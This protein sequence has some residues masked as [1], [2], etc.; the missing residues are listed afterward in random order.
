MEDVL[1]EPE[2]SSQPSTVTIVSEIEV[3]IDLSEEQKLYACSAFTAALIQDCSETNDWTKS[4]LER[5]YDYFSLDE[6]LRRKLRKLRVPPDKI[7]D[8]LY[9]DEVSRQMLLYLLGFALGYR[10]GYDA[11]ARTALLVVTTSWN[12]PH[13]AL[14]KCENDLST[15][16]TTVQS[17]VT[18]GSSS[19]TS[20][21]SSSSSPVTFWKRKTV[22][23]GVAAVATGVVLAA[24]GLAIVFP[25]V[26]GAAK[27]AS[28]PLAAKGI[29]AILSGVFGA[30]GAGLAGYKVDRRT[31]PV[32]EFSFL[33]IK[34]RAPSTPLHVV[35]G[36]PGLIDEN[37]T[38]EGLLDLWQQT[39]LPLEG[40]TYVLRWETGVLRDL[41][42]CVERMVSKPIVAMV[43]LANVIDSPWVVAASRAEK[44]G[45]LLAAVLSQRIHGNRPVS[46]VAASMGARLVFHALLE[47]H[48]I[49]AYGVVQDVVLLGTPVSSDNAAEWRCVRQVVARHLIVGFSANDPQLKSASRTFLLARNVAGLVPFVMTSSLSS[50][51]NNDDDDE[52][53]NDRS[54]RRNHQ[55]TL[56]GA[57]KHLSWSDGPRDMRLKQVG[58]G[59][60]V[61]G[62]SGGAIGGI[63]GVD[64]SRTVE[65]HLSYGNIDLPGVATVAYRS[66]WT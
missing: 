60:G 10:R 41:G 20:S 63:D 27:L 30:A 49:G 57:L 22:L 11:R 47:M 38:D 5:L 65:S 36:V 14:V 21:S 12:L 45:A 34:A 8:N 43:D 18:E 4:L 17:L 23:A 31:V 32:D 39:L 2:P 40:E 24:S 46:L 16:L 48:K 37:T 59:D 26:A 55:R 56:V 1:N 58:G 53:V 51:D 25:V 3:K 29:S 54:S 19:S 66:L 52:V 7:K 9:S 33:S 44:A 15:S 13:E 35:I 28:L 62:T 50:P 61:A 6:T 42:K 64:V